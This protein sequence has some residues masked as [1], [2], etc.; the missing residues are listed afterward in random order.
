MD[1]DY[2]A[3]G[4]R[5][6]AYRK[7]RKMS[8]EEL[9]EEIDISVPHMCNIENGKTKFSLPILVGLANALAVRPDALLYDQIGENWRR[10][11]PSLRTVPRYRCK[12]SGKLSAMKRNF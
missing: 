2:L 6:K 4:K 3:I 10:S 7:E 12:C 11:K 9:A 1:I 5:I 8:Q